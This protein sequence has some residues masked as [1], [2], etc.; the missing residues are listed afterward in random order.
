MKDIKWRCESCGEVF[1]EANKDYVNGGYRGEPHYTCPYCG[2]DELV[3]M[4]QCELCGE[5]FPGDEIY[6]HM[7]EMV[8]NDCIEKNTNEENVMDFS[9]ENLV[10]VGIPEI[11]ADNF[12]EDEITDILY[13]WFKDSLSE[14]E[15]LNIFKEEVACNKSEFAEYLNAKGE[16]E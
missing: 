13:K 2:S 15:K 6:G 8:C 7:G 16:E 12:S 10:D 3:D 9:K 4:F 5:W 14:F 1:D 11:I